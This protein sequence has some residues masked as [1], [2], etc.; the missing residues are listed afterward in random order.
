MNRVLPVLALLCLGA[1][2]LVPG[3]I[4]AGTGGSGF[5]GGGTTSPKPGTKKGVKKKGA[6][7]RVKKRIANGKTVVGIA[8]QSGDTFSDP[9]FAG[10]GVKNARL[11]LAW[12]ALEYDWQVAELDAWMAN[13]R[14][15][16][17][18]P[19]VIF[20]QSRV[21]GRTR[22]LP[23]PAQYGAVVDQLRA[24]YPFLNEFAAWNEMNYP[25]QPTFK[26]PKAVA[27][28]YKV[29]RT[30]CPGCRILP[31]SLLD[32]PN[33]VPWTLTLQA[34]I[35][36]LRQPEPKIWGL[37]N[38]SD[39]NRL[40]DTSTQKL[41]AAVKGKIWLTETGGV[42]AAT[43]PTASRYPQGAAYAGKVTAY[44]L[45]TLVKQNPR[46]ERTY[47]YEWKAPQGPVSWDSGL[48]S[49]TDVKRPAYDIVKSYVS[50]GTFAKR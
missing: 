24:R 39:V 12:D 21:K 19:L 13:A 31:G 43:S 4:A 2:L 44:I 30:K 37:H 40:R 25:G 20:S 18:Q 17:V 49:P 9:L 46:I 8:D 41:L 32:N 10:L 27:Q 26:K 6:K 15:A 16:G 48:V 29:L 36:K 5:D 11:N 47:L 23:T 35:K 22:I 33:L 14:A 7:K 45:G 42:V 3:A 34:E 1:V 28:Y 50:T 38:Y